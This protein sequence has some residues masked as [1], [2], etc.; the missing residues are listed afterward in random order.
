MQWFLANSSVVGFVV[1]T[2][3]VTAFGVRAL[4]LL[5]RRRRTNRRAARRAALLEAEGLSSGEAQHQAGRLALLEHLG[6]DTDTARRIAELER[7]GLSYDQAVEQAE[8]EASAESQ[9]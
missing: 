6:W 9:P 2:A 3:L 8:A 5:R 4:L 1:V 7:T